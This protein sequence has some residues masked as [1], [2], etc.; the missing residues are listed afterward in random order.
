MSETKNYIPEWIFALKHSSVARHLDRIVPNKPLEI[1]YRRQLST[2]PKV[3]Y[4]EIPFKIN[5]DVEPT[6]T[7][8]QAHI[9]E[10]TK[11]LG[12]A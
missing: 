8:I 7:L 10:V 11:A 6:T 9:D 12:A 2:T 4:E 3:T 5:V 1:V